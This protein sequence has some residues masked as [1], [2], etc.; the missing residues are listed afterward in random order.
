MA[1]LLFKSPSP[2]DKTI[3]EVPS[4]P[5]VT[6]NVPSLPTASAKV[7]VSKFRH[8]NAPETQAKTKVPAEKI[9]HNRGE[10]GKLVTTK[11]TQ[12]Q[13]APRKPNEK[14]D[15]QPHGSQ[16]EKKKSKV[17]PCGAVEGLNASLK[18]VREGPQL[19]PVKQKK[20]LPPTSPSVNFKPFK[21]WLSLDTSVVLPK[22]LFNSIGFLW[23]MFHVLFFFIHY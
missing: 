20:V 11:T 21:C 7:T 19:E 18:D 13:T 14:K 15:I 22:T 6:A 23:S 16:A 5:V 8:K 2:L 4:K 3:V 10:K 9:D 17:K 1:D 12:T